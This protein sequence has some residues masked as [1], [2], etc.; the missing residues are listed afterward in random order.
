VR[1]R[2]ANDYHADEFAN[3]FSQ[4]V[5]VIRAATRHDVICSNFNDSCRAVGKGGCAACYYSAY[6][7][8]CIQSGSRP[9][10]RQSLEVVNTYRQP[11]T[12]GL[13]STATTSWYNTVKRQTIHQT[14]PKRWFMLSLPVDLTT[15]THC[16]LL[17]P[18]NNWS[19]Y[20]TV[21]NPATPMVT[22][23]RRSD[24]T[25]ITPVLKVLHWLSVSQR[26]PYEMV[27]LVHKFLH[28]RCAKIPHHR[29]TDWCWVGSRRSGA[30]G[31][32]HQML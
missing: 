1:D 24:H 28:E 25:C 13:L 17:W 30:R 10:L 14:R 2:P 18:T 32:G 27:M 9:N 22:G 23:I 3:Y 31:G 19:D 21:H 4:K 11:L 8:Y 20:S 6:S 29:D 5:S 12:I 26:I 7:V 16:C 15:V